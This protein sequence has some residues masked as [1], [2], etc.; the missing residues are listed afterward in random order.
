MNFLKGFFQVCLG[1]G[2]IIG[3]SAAGVAWVGACFATVIIGVLLLIFA[4]HI[5][6]F[7]FGIA[8]HGIAYIESGFRFMTG[9]G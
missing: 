3:F 1:L 2:I 6:L 8:L 7:P 4:P 9:K 5:L